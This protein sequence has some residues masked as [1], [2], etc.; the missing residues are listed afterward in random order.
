M[1]DNL[2]LAMRDKKRVRNYHGLPVPKET[3]ELHT[4]WGPRLDP[5]GEKDISSDN[6]HQPKL[7]SNRAVVEPVEFT[8][9]QNKGEQAPWSNMKCLSKRG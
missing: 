8:T 5:G 1:R 2:Q 6:T 3:G 9:H 7:S 4:T